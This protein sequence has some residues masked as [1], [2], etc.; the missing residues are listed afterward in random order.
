MTGAHKEEAGV[1]ADKVNL[2]I[3]EVNLV[4]WV[5]ACRTAGPS[6]VLP[7]CLLFL[8]HEWEVFSVPI[9]LPWNICRNI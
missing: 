4:K 8:K 2:R 1:F 3:V 9:F 7:L 6:D 5:F